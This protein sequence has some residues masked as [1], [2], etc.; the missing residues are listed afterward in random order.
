VT[1]KIHRSAAMRKMGA[2]TLIDL[3][4]IADALKPDATG[5]MR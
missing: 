3:V 5:D 1:V 4:R 2:C